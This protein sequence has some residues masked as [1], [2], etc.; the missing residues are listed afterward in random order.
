MEDQ[1]IYPNALLS[2]TSNIP[3]INA[4]IKNPAYLKFDSTNVIL[5][6][7]IQPEIILYHYESLVIYL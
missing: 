4:H 3:I 5:Q 1:S 6:I 2:L 7:D